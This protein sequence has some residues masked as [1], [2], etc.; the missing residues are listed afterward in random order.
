MIKKILFFTF[1]LGLLGAGCNKTEPINNSRETYTNTKYGY[2]VEYPSGYVVDTFKTTDAGE[3]LPT[4]PAQADSN[5]VTISKNG[6]KNWISINVYM[7]AL[8]LTDENVGKGFATNPTVTKIQVANL[9]GY[10]LTF[11]DTPYELYFVQK[12]NGPRIGI[13][14]PVNN[15]L[16]EDMLKSFSFTN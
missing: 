1:F 16:S 11:P 13:K 8:P 6:S 10:K 15:S 12:F 3:D 4:T 2:K 9:P 5:P 14:I 7:G